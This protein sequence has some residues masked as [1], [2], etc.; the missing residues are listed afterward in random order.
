[1]I[2]KAAYFRA[3]GRGF[4]AGDR[5]RDWLEAQAEVDAVLLERRGTPT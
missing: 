5:V 2:A 3:E 1:M 4:Q